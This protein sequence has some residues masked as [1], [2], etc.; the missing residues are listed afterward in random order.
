MYILFPHLFHPFLSALV[1]LLLIS[2]TTASTPTPVPSDRGPTSPSTHTL[3]SSSG[4]KPL[5]SNSDHSGVI[6]NRAEFTTDSYWQEQVYDGT[7][8]AKPT[9]PPLR[10]NKPQRKIPP[11]PPPPPVRPTVQQ[12]E[13]VQKVLADVTRRVIEAKT[14]ESKNAAAEAEMPEGTG[15]DPN[16][17][18]EPGTPFSDAM[19]V[20]GREMAVR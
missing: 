5:A 13:Q 15:Y 7:T 10:K 17:G 11:P 20:L 2:S 19:T 9:P 4:T 3:I 18:P 6:Q 16:A 12:E 14:D 8:V 1:L